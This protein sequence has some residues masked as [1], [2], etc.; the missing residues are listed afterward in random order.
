MTP[1]DLAIASSTPEAATKP[2]RIVHIEISRFRR[3]QAVRL[4][5]EQDTTVLVGANNSGKTAALVAMR[6]FLRDRKGFS[7][8]DIGA[9]SWASLRSLGETWAALTQDPALG[10]EEDPAAPWEKQLHLLNESMPAV[11]V[12]LD[13]Q[14]GEFHFVSHLIPTLDW[15]G[16]LLGVRLRLEPATDVASIQKLAWSYRQARVLAQA[17]KDPI[18]ATRAWPTDLLDYWLR[19]PEQ[20]GTIAAYKLD[21][22][23]LTNVDALYRAQPQ[24]LPADATRLQEDPLQKIV[25]VDFVPAQR[26]LG[27]EEADGRGDRESQR[28]GMFSQQLVQLARRRFDITSF[29]QQGQQEMQAA[30]ARAQAGLDLAISDA[31]KDVTERVRALGYPGLH[32]P[33]DLVFRSRVRP[34]DLLNHST[35]VQYSMDETSGAPIHLPEH[36]IGLGYQNLQS[37]TYKLYAFREE[38]FEPPGADP[39]IAPVPVH[40]VLVEEPE[41]HLHVQAQRVFVTRAYEVLKPAATE[42]QNLSSQLVITTHSSHIAH[43]VSFAKLRYV[44]RG[45]PTSPGV[46]PTSAV[47]GLHNVFGKDEE[48]NLRFAERYL[49]IQHSD[50][51]FADAAVFVEGTAERLLVPQFVERGWPGLASRYLSYL[52]VGGSHAHR[53]RPLVERLGLPTLII[54]D[55]DPATEITNQ[56]GKV[57]KKKAPVVPDQPQVSTNPTLANWCPVESSIPE[58]LAI[59]PD[60]K[61]ATVGSWPGVQVRVAYQISG[62]A[63]RPCG[64]TFEDAFVLEN[65]T[66]F[67]KLEETTGSMEAM[68]IVATGISDRMKLAGRTSQDPRRRLRQGAVRARSTHRS[69]RSCRHRMPAV[70]SRG[71][72]LA[73]QPTHPR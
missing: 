11:D 67:A 48:D 51:L 32:D 36:S 61:V 69:P 41:A 19:H 26:G 34:G 22:A 24:Q 10:G 49:R 39:G 17:A 70:H 58:L 35:A 46:V 12:W 62:A 44:R 72:R 3:L 27:T 8:Y 65:E 25:R 13:A 42:H 43:A 2:L 38:R 6:L 7:P 50:L 37:L 16:G 57:S 14:P 64:T 15:E 29:E 55:L 54:T 66:F 30:V 4:D 59:K 71:P 33:Q 63:D 56:K 47:I 18:A 40:L 5:L 23:K 20:L 21:P 31:L 73:E 45:A 52:E 1:T 53:L 28:P 9:E 60:A 68:R